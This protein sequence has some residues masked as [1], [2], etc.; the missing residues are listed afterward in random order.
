MDIKKYEFAE[1]IIDTS[2]FAADEL[3]FSVLIGIV[4]AKSTL[5][6]TNHRRFVICYSC[7]PHPVWIW[8]AD[9]ITAMEKEQIWQICQA[10]HLLPSA[11]GTIT[12]I[13]MK[14]SLAEYFNSKNPAYGIAMEL[15]VYECFRTIPPVKQVDGVLAEVR[16]QDVE[17]V[18]EFMYRFHQETGVDQT[19]H[20]SCRKQAQTVVG[21]TTFHLWRNALGEN[22]AMCSGKPAGEFGKVAYV[23]CK[24]EE[25]RKGYVQQ[26]VYQ[27]TKK[28][29]DQGLRPILYTD[30]NYAASNG[31]YK[32]VGYE[33][34]GGLCTVGM[35][36]TLKEG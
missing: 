23:Y 3:T 2:L 30:G 12:G 22:V 10:E 18:A 14:Y 36:N 7:A 32:K 6:V 1:N 11:E 24:P 25:R 21:K 19:D 29:L 31:C 8:T 20:E 15:L 16:L 28:L 26:M 9:D 17:E 33:Q 34:Q 13:N 4:N 5:V 27:V 35:T